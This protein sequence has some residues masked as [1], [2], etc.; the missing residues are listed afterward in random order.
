LP[1]SALFLVSFFYVDAETTVQILDHKPRHGEDT[2][3]K[4]Y[5]EVFRH[6]RQIN[7]FFSAPSGLWSEQFAHQ[8][9]VFLKHHVYSQIH[10]STLKKHSSLAG[11]YKNARL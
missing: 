2:L 5:P 1:E 7:H 8:L 10:R 9:L 3:K 6:R 4:H 11:F